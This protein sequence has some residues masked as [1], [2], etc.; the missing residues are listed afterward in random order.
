M[1]SL[2]AY[3]LKRT[4]KQG[5]WYVIPAVALLPLITL[6]SYIS[7]PSSVTI[8][9]NLS[10]YP[11]MI[12][13]ATLFSTY[14]LIQFFVSDRRKGFFEYILA[15]T[16]IKVRSIYLALLLGAL[17][18]A[19]IPVTI[20]TFIFYVL[21]DIVQHLPK[22]F[23]MMLVFSIP[24]S[25]IVPPMVIVVASTWSVMTRPIRGT[26]GVQQA[27]LAPGIGV[28]LIEGPIFYTF[29][30]S[31]PKV[32]STLGIYS[33]TLFFALMTLFLITIRIQRADRFL[34]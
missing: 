33:I 32:N 11:E 18:L 25:F 19:A 23:Y 10:I 13:L 5:K 16:E 30:N 4:F 7:N 26:V 27:G 21:Y 34:P 15:T 20:D 9:E 22:E 1:F 14:P 3:Y 29:I 6:S 2:S 8:A 17:T 24:I 31:S 28:I 12:P